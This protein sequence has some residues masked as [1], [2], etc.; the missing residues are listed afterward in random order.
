MFHHRGWTPGP[1]LHQN[2][3]QVWTY[4]GTAGIA[5]R[6]AYPSA[7]ALAGLESPRY[8][9]NARRTIETS[10]VGQ[11]NTSLP[12]RPCDERR[13][14]AHALA[15]TTPRIRQ[16]TRNGTAATTTEYL[17]E[18]SRTPH[19]AER[20][21]LRPGSHNRRFK[22]SEAVTGR[23][24]AQRCVHVS[25]D[26]S[27]RRQLQE[28]SVHLTPT[29][30]QQGTCVLHV[31][32]AWPCLRLRL[33]TTRSSRYG[34]VEIRSERCLATPATTSHDARNSP[35]M[36]RPP[37]MPDKP[38][39]SQEALIADL[40]PFAAMPPFSRDR[41]NRPCSRSSCPNPSC[42]IFSIVSRRPPC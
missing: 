23:R 27:V 42:R 8:A 7:T 19:T 33:S 26:V 39:L 29:P 6:D 30:H 1:S 17:P 28:H 25:A 32:Q 13:W 35:S 4:T 11:M 18:R 36:P 22:A 24:G 9:Q 34:R 20:A 37:A 40:P 5:S 31:I 2:L 16:R 41:H 10:H 3:A 14:T 15:C 38:S 21:P 12:R